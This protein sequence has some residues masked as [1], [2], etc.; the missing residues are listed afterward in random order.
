[1]PFEFEHHFKSLTMYAEGGYIVNEHESPEGW[2]GLAGEYELSEKF[3]LMGEI[4]GGWDRAFQ[5][6]G[7]SFNIGFR[8]PLTEYVALIGSAGRGIFGGANRAPIFQG[9]LALQW[10]F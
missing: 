10:T 9:Y 7:G 5:H 8:R 3:S 2:Y 1:L 4:Y 6:T